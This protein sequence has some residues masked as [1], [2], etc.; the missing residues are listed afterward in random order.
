M[1]YLARKLAD[2]HICIVVL[3]DRGQ[4]VARLNTS[5]A[6]HR[7]IDRHTR[8]GIA[9]EIVG[10]AFKARGVRIDDSSIVPHA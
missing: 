6:Q 9:P 8:H 1:E 5:S 10:Q 7:L 3:C 4:R 2:H